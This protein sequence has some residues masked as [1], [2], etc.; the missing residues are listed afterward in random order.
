M[1]DKVTEAA[2]RLATGVSR[3][4]FLSGL[5]RGALATAGV[6][7]GILAFGGTA[8]AQVF[9]PSGY[10]RCSTSGP[11]CPNHTRCCTR[12]LTYYCSKQKC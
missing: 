1:F 11:C 8:R 12:G 10:Y 4:A 2:E 6:L 5:G 9:C 3:R 7:A